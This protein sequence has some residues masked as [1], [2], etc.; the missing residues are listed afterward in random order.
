MCIYVEKIME[1][2]TL[3][4]Y[5]WSSQGEGGRVDSFFLCSYLVSKISTV[6]MF[7]IC[8]EKNKDY[9]YITSNLAINHGAISIAV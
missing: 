3:H 2:C 8:N 5:Q 7:N 4:S 6:N 1:S 9:F